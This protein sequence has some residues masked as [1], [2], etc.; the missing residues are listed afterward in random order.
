AQ[1]ARHYTAAVRL[2]GLAG[3]RDDLERF[4]PLFTKNPLPLKLSRQSTALLDNLE[5]HE[6]AL[7]DR[8]IFFGSARLAVS[9][10]VYC[11]MCMYGCPYSFIYSSAFTVQELRENPRFSYR[12]DVIVD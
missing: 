4:F 7:A 3:G 6:R 9:N 12:P 5:R 2:T 8:G 10:C 11:T 1:L